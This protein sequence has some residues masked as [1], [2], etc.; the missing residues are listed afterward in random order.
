[1]TS[2]RQIPEDAETTNITSTELSTTTVLGAM[3]VVE[4]AA[5]DVLDSSWLEE[6][7]ATLTLYRHQVTGAEFLAY[8]PNV[9][10]SGLGGEDEGGYDPKPDKVFGV[11]FRTKTESSSGLPHI[12]ERECYFASHSYFNSL[13][14][15]M[16]DCYP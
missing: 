6:Y 10:R 11:S 5:Y 16:T 3:G 8:V 15:I 1:M 7:E 13:S 12:L 2:S 9:T 14:S 4:H